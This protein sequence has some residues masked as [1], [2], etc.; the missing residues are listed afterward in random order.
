[1]KARKMTV[2]LLSVVLLLVAANIAIAHQW[3]GWHLHKKTIGVFIYGA[4]QVS[5]A[6]AL[7]DWGPGFNVLRP[8]RVTHHSDVSLFD[9]NAGN[10]GWGGLASIETYFNH[11]HSSFL[12]ICFS[13][14]PGIIHAHARLNT[15]YGWAN[16]NTGTTADDGRGVQCQELGHTFGLD[17]SND[18]CMGKGYFNNLNFVTSHS[19]ADLNAM[20]SGAPLGDCA[21]GC[22]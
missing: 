18:G 22:F 15:F 3:D 5:S 11:C 17:H 19:D 12:G 21:G 14:Q 7:R 20:Y 10:T 1:M 4:N 16:L 13:S 6:A 9:D 8:I 2:A